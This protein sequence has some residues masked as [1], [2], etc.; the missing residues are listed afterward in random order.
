VQNWVRAFADAYDRCLDCGSESPIHPRQLTGG[1]GPAELTS[2]DALMSGRD[3]V[4]FRASASQSL[5]NPS[6]NRDDLGRRA[7]FRR[8]GAMGNGLRT[9]CQWDFQAPHVFADVGPEQSLFK[10]AVTCPPLC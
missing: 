7:G 1:C 6:F 4:R 10:R 2:P 9:W 3:P 5:F 8:S